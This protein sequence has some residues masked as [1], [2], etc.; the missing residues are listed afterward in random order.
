M[1]KSQFIKCESLCVILFLI[2]NA[3]MENMAFVFLNRYL[4][5]SEVG[6]C[7]IYRYFSL[8]CLCTDIFRTA[9]WLII[10]SPIGVLVSAQLL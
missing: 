3:G 5:I 9:L 7:G 8:H 4:D 1:E 6:D 10:M 2:Q